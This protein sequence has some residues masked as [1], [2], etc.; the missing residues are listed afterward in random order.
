MVMMGLVGAAAGTTPAPVM[1]GTGTGAATSATHA[2]VKLEA[3]RHVNAGRG[4]TL[5]GRVQP[6][7]S[8]QVVIRVG[9]R[10]VRS[11]R[12]GNDGR[13]KVEWRPP[14]AGTYTATALLP[15]GGANSRPQRI[16]VYRPAAAS[17]YG[18]GL[19]GGA[20]ACG[21]RLSPGTVGVANRTL[22]CGARVTLRYHG[23]TVTVPVVDRGPFSGGR[24]YDLTAATKAKLRFPST[25]TVLTTR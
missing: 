10:K 7:G 13:F 6:A 17:Y 25:G 22:P 4:V 20:L 3:R 5:H 23:K 21:G 2:S 19:Y 15:G 12:A 9:G 11:V 8:R 24:E 1:G 16:N 18:P 14:H